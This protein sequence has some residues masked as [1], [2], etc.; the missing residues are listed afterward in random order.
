MV[1]TGHLRWRLAHLD[2]MATGARD[3]DPHRASGVAGCHS[4][5]EP[6]VATRRRTHRDPHLPLQISV[7]RQ[8]LTRIAHR[9]S[10][11]HRRS[12][13]PQRR[14]CGAVPRGTPS[15]GVDQGGRRQRT[16]RSGSAG[17]RGVE[18]LG[19][20]KHRSRVMLDPGVCGEGLASATSAC[21]RAVMGV[22]MTDVQPSGEPAPDPTTTRRPDHPGS[23]HRYWER[24]PGGAAGSGSSTPLAL[25][26]RRVTITPTAPR[27]GNPAERAVQRGA[28]PLR[29]RPRRTRP[30]RARPDPGRRV[31]S[32]SSTGCTTRLGRPGELRSTSSPGRGARWRAGSGRLPIGSAAPLPRIM[33]VANQ[34]G[35]VGKTTTTVNLGASLAELDHRV[36][37]VDL[38]PQGNAT[39]GLGINPRT[40]STRCT[41]SC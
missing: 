10:R 33:A 37:V 17:D 4:G 19:A 30:R 15:G 22:R 21:A 3:P 12:V 18:P 36:L 2:P 31:R 25:G 29:W 35:G 20:V 24:L 13:R 28:V 1:D 27:L 6:A 16:H 32:D 26:A 34:K 39:T 41:T 8:I 11:R 38:D 7:F 5:G 23:A 40:S 14:W 9:C